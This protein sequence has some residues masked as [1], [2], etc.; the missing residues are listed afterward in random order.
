[1]TTVRRQRAATVARPGDR[2]RQNDDR[3]PQTIT[4]LSQPAAAAAEIQRL[5]DRLA[6]ERTIPPAVAVAVRE[7]AAGIEETN[8]RRWETIDP[9]HAVIVLRSALSARRALD[10]PGSPAAR[11]E[12][13]V[14]LESIRQSLAA[15]AER[16]PV[17]DE[18]PPKQIVQWLAGRPRSRR[19]GWP[20]CSA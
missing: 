6:G 18:R 1:M 11:D 7:I 5:N 8:T 3:R 2:S 9:T 12:L 13:R 17:S 16:E 10:E 4:D 14:A 15:I 20:S 19:R